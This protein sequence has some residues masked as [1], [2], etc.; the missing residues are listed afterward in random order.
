MMK[1]NPKPVNFKMG[2][3]ISNGYEFLKGNFGDILVAFLLCIIM[4]VIPF[5]GL[6]AIGNFYRYCR[7]LRAGKQVSA[8][9]IFNFDNFLPYFIMQ[10]I[11]LAG[12]V[13]LYIPMFIFIPIMA[14]NGE[15][16]PV[17]G[18]LYVLYMIF[19]YIV[20][21]IVALKAFYMVALIS[22]GGITDVKT[23]WNISVIMGKGNL[24][25]MF[26]FALV[27]GILG[28]LGVLACVIGLIFTMPF[29]Y[30]AQYFA[31]ED[32]LKQVTYDEIQ[33]IGIKDDF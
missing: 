20:V 2:D 11:F 22:L 23:A 24:L 31:L 19:L 29:V 14:G 3:Y 1:I 18:I 33:E 25:S 30:T 21:I 28:Y 5:C 13:I 32:G 9:D 16:S 12:F 8:G 4:S 10:L 15:P 7:D 27:I 6:L 17:M 26:L